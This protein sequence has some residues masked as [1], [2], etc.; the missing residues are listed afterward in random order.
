MFTHFFIKRPIFAGV[1]SLVIL[2]VGGF[3]IFSLPI[4]RYPDIAPPT[5][6]VNT[7]YP[8]ADA[9]TVAQTVA[10]P[11]EQEVN[12]VEGMIY[13][14]SVSANDGS[15]SLTVTFETG[16][17]LD[18][19]NVLVQNR[20]SAATPKLP[21]EAR[22]MGVKVEK[23]MSSANLFIAFSSP[24]GTRDDFFL[25]N[26]LN[27]SVK[28]EIARVNGVG[29][30]SA[31]G[32]GEFSIRIWLD[33]QR[34]QA[35][36]VST[37]EVMNAV[38][39]QNQQVA[40]GQIG[41]PPVPAGQAYQYVINVKGRL[42]DTDEFG[43][44]V[45]RT[46]EDGQMIRLRDVATVQLGS[47]T[48]LFSARFNGRPC[49]ALSVYQIPGANALAVADG[50]KAKLA[51]LSE[52][53]PAGITYDIAF[54]NTIVIEASLDEMLVTLMITLVLVVLT[55]FLFLQNFR[56]TLIPAMTIP[57]SLIGT[58]AVLAAL[59]F[60]L[61]QFTLFGLILVI[62]IVVD[63]AIVVVENCTTHLAKGAKDSK[64]A[65]RRAMNEVT[66]P[67][68]ATT[69][70]LLAVF[71]P[72]AF[73]GGITGI[74]FQQF[75]VTIAVATVF[76]SINA[77]TLS[78]A[79]CGVL[80]RPSSGKP[81][82]AWAR[83]FN[84]M[85]DAG[86]GVL[87]AAVTTVLKRFSLG[88]VVFVALVIAAGWGFVRLPGGFVPQEDEGYCIVA[89][90]L[91][92]ASS[93][94]RTRA[95][96]EQVEAVVAKTE[97]VRYNLAITGYSLLD[98]AVVP[99]AGFCYVIFEDWS[100]RGA[101]ASQS[102][103]I[104]NLNRELR[105]L[106][107]GL[108][109]AFASP[110]LPG[111]GLSGGFSA[112]LQQRGGGDLNNL[113]QV[114]DEF[115]VDGN[116]QA[117]LT[118][119][120]T[121]FSARAPQLFVDI[122]R[123]QV[124]AKNIPMSSVFGA[125]QTFLGSAYI[126]DV[127]LF[128]RVYKVKAQADPRFR[129][130]TDQIL[131]YELKNRAGDM[132]PLGAVVKVDEILGPQVVKRFNLYP[133]AKIMGNAAPGYSSGQA[134][135]IVEDMG[136]QKLPSSM[137]LAW[138]ELSYQEAAA[139]GGTTVIFL[140]AVV[141]VYL[142]LAAQYES[143]SIPISVCLAVPTALLGAVIGLV[144]RGYANDVYAQVGIVLL[145]GLSTKSAILISEFAKAER[146]SGMSTFEAALSAAKLRFRAV[147]MTAL[148]F[149]LG[150]IPLLIAS[151]AGAESR[152]IIGTTV[153]AGMMVATV[154]SLVAVPMLY[155]VVQ[156]LV[157]KMSGSSKATRP[158]AEEDSPVADNS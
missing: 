121:T 62:G 152:K 43:R 24:D 30:V 42:Q 32:V 94:E 59:G 39:E 85:M 105:K 69:L 144:A 29:K 34:M 49:A 128:N 101:N 36:S 86:T 23:Q 89:V 54:D 48:Y 44:I 6:V 157:E 154:V 4:D 124:L 67:V 120:N 158:V 81:L 98:G 1:I 129:G 50:V 19:A 138:T 72:T 51:E 22:R 137:G 58:F 12:G 68:I 119:L 15:M 145:I 38:R 45:I 14:E 151:G 76:S 136:R 84:R 10:T 25:S 156:L 37:D 83:G 90:Q 109:F 123:D 146:E 5:V 18:M 9:Q 115:V 97:G 139:S 3:S 110:S 20:V 135:E 40:A 122:D 7:V 55:V 114:A 13:M 96:V 78:P 60:S 56:A 79:L 71:V 103:I 95:F 91:P 35:A 93:Q 74:L 28:D 155:Y 132:V 149:I 31:F 102:A 116:A 108:S 130:E 147:L 100:E 21:E 27:Q 80:L 117:G 126:N 73:M 125:M 150:V 26:Y 118:G 143:W 82:P 77:L 106:Q 66:G 87:G 61:N 104:A 16:T 88:V 148:S 107:E 113:Q 142:V 140:I 111:L 112:Q 64:E 99:N 127:T 131:Q 47:D 134:M 75:A 133:S 52:A 2:L 63:D 8:G 33:P 141:L 65:A 53:F 46:G 41:E 11:I 57:V 92:D 17:D 153:F 70:V